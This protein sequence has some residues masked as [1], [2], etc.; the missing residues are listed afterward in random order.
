[1]INL[2][3]LLSVAFAQTI[4]LFNNS[5]EIRIC[6]ALRRKRIV[7]DTAPTAKDINLQQSHQTVF[8][9]YYHLDE[10]VAALAA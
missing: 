2:H 1:M 10:Q 5:K 4:D 6:S 7:V 3:A 8:E 9:A